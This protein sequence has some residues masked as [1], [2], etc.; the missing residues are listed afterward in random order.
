MSAI[1]ID[2]RTFLQVCRISERLASTR[3]ARMPYINED[4]V[5]A[6][7][8]KDGTA[9][10][11]A[12]FGGGDEELTF[13]RWDWETVTGTTEF[14]FTLI[15]RVRLCELEAKTRLASRVGTDQVLRAPAPELGGSI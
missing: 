10:V 4:H 11:G 13:V 8:P 14:G 3:R 15:P 12:G 5:K 6:T 7:M 2:R 9:R 1:E